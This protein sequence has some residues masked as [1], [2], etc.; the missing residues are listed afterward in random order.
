MK[1]SKMLKVGEFQKMFRLSIGTSSYTPGSSVG[2]VL[3]GP[4]YFIA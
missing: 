2:G 4:C 1:N 3:A